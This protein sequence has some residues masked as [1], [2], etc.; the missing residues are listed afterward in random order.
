MLEAVALLALT[1]DYHSGRPELRYR[2][3]YRTCCLNSH[4]GVQSAASFR[5]RRSTA[6]L[7][8]EPLPH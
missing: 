1:T 3:E 8:P 4:N 2:R 5:A 7:A 6:P